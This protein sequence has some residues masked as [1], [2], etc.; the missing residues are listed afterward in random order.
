MARIQCVLNY[1]H[2]R[3]YYIKFPPNCSIQGKH[4]EMQQC[5]DII[6]F[7]VFTHFISPIR[8]WPK[9]MKFINEEYIANYFF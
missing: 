4:G 5:H 1:V 2:F 9:A 8:S 6:P 3:R 7:N